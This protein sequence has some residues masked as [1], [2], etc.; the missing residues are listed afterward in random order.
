MFKIKNS[1]LIWHIIGSLAFLALPV[2][3]SPH[4]PEEVNY[5][6]QK[7]TIRDFISNFFMLA[8][9]YANYYI[10]IPD[11]FLK[12][13]YVKYFTLILISFLILIYLPTLLAEHVPGLEDMPKKMS[14]NP[15][16]LLPKKNTI[17][18]FFRPINLVNHNVLLYISVVLLSILLR[19]REQLFETEKSKNKAELNSLKNQINPHFLFNTLNS[20]YALAV[21]D[22]SEITADSIL[23]LSGM[24][25]YVVTETESNYVS[26]EKELV[27]IK[28]YI[29]LQRL[30]IDH[31]VQ[32]KVEIEGDPIGKKIVPLILIPFVENAF[33]HGVNPEKHSQIDIFITILDNKLNL[34]VSNLKTQN[35]LAHYEK[36]GHGTENVKSRLSLLYPENY[37]LNIFENEEVYQVDLTLNLE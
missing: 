1:T 16:P 4:P 2:F 14:S 18:T 20:I 26:L 32:L 5:L 3:I 29:D 30:R 35:Q 12:K 28:N 15:R 7:P 6:F 21:R 36:S 31:R 27:Y 23:K 24:M 9:F 19:I 22:G 8:F 25:R 34:K 11:I 17:E 13:Q 10:L 33:K 37:Q